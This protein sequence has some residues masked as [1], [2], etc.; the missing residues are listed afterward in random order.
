[1]LSF[2]STNEDNYKESKEI[3]QPFL[4]LF[5]EKALGGRKEMEWVHPNYK[6]LPNGP[7]LW[8][9]KSHP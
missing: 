2:F 3:T 8:E 6:E 5:V 1:M 4:Y 9:M 7:K